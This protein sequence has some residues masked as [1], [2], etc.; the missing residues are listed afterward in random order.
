MWERLYY[1]QS[2]KVITYLKEDKQKE[3]ELVMLRKKPTFLYYSLINFFSNRN[4]LR[5]NPA[6]FEWVLTVTLVLLSFLSV[7]F[8]YLILYI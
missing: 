5:I 4:V 2:T 3:E 6:T 7:D 8:W 1:K